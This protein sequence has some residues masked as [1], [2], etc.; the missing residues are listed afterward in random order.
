MEKSPDKAYPKSSL[1]VE[2]EIH[3]SQSNSGQWDDAVY[4]YSGHGGHEALKNDN[5]IH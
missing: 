1:D 2:P 5:G 4:Q 3:G